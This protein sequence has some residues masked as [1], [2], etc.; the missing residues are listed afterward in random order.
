[1]ERL[2]LTREN[3]QTI[4]FVL[5]AFA[6]SAID[7]GELHDWCSHVIAELDVA[8]VPDYVFDLLDYQGKLA[9]IYKVV[10]FVPSWGQTD[11]QS[12]ALYGIALERGRSRYEWPMD[13]EVALAALERNPQIRRHFRDT[14]PF[15]TY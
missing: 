11:E 5:S 8:D 13:Q 3:S 10:G 12:A 1:M 4:G 2:G 7:L 6:A 9:G 15:I 14:F